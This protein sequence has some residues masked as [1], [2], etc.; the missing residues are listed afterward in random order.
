M[1][2]LINV[3]KFA[4]SAMML[5]LIARHI[6]IDPD[7]W[8]LERFTAASLISALLIL[9][10][11]QILAAGRLSMAIKMADE[12]LT[13][14]AA[15]R[16][17][18]IGYFFGQTFL[19]FLGGDASRMWELKKHGVGL[20]NAGAG[21]VLDR[22]LGLVANHVLVL[23]ML[24]WTLALM[25]DPLQRLTVLIVA[26]GGTAGI[27]LLCALAYLRGRM[28]LEG[29]LL[30]RFGKRPIISA[31]L[32]IVSVLR[33]AFREPGTAAAATLLGAVINILNAVMIWV[34]F[35]GLGVQ[36]SFLTVLMLVP[37]IMELAMVPITMAGWGVRE[38]LMVVGFGLAG[39]ASGPA[40]MTSLM[41]GL[42]GVGFSLAGC[43]VWLWGRTPK[44]ARAGGQA[45]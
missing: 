26:L 31:L 30:E 7:Q 29:R 8:R 41:F 19:S 17:T 6:G 33:L 14:P 11:Q 21:V 45:E 15:L 37:L 38:G 27:L 39:V 1:G 28:G 9:T 24:P 36:V 20:R 4:V 22:L 23:A 12:M 35:L 3:A 34:L 43:A 42:L 16:I 13:F 44:Q 25:V 40:F 18:L 5:W 10:L 32:D 2:W